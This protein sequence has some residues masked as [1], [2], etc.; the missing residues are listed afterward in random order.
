MGTM[1]ATSEP[2]SFQAWRQG[3]ENGQSIDQLQDL[4]TRFVREMGW[5]LAAGGRDHDRY[6]ESS[7]TLYVMARLGEKAV[8]GMRLTE[9]DGN[10]NDCLSIEM[11]RANRQL[12]QAARAIVANLSGDTVYDVTRLVVDM[13]TPPELRMR[14]IVGS[15]GCAMASLWSP[16]GD[17]ERSGMAAWVGTM[18]ALLWRA[19]RGVEIPLEQQIAGKLMLGDQHKTIFGVVYPYKLLQDDAAARKAKAIPEFTDGWR[20]GLDEVL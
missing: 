1:L 4:R 13:T 9:L 10:R 3:E 8:A 11:L 15:I 6:D 14:A 16:E 19:L 7:A 5:P 18:T 12:Q 20:A 17:E 2:L